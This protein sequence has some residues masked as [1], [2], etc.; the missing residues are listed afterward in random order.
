MVK[1]NT[2]YYLTEITWMYSLLLWCKKKKKFCY[3]KL[4]STC[5]TCM[6]L[7]LFCHCE[8]DSPEWQGPG[9]E[10]PGP[11]SEQPGTNF[12]Q[13]AEDFAVW[14]YRDRSTAKKDISGTF[15]PC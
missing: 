9:G 10:R 6:H 7:R 13:A 11:D 1:I 3:I 5:I 2:E 14:E 8:D 15:L 4:K 12:N